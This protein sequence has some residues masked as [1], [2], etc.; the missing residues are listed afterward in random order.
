M[1]RA[2]LGKR[3]WKYVLVLMQNAAKIFSRRK[4]GRQNMKIHALQKPGAVQNHAPKGDK[5]NLGGAG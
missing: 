4:Y 1:M 3:G 5:K 2:E